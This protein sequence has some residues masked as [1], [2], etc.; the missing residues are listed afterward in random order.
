VASGAVTTTGSGFHDGSLERAGAARE[1]APPA[2]PALRVEAHGL[3]DGHRHGGDQQRDRRQERDP[4][5]ARVPVGPRPG[6]RIP[7]A[8][9]AGVAEA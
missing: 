7:D 3:V 1:L 2:Q 5:R 4:R 8:G 6:A 9:R